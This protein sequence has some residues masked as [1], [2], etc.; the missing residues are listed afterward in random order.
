MGS[1]R[2]AQV[3]WGQQRDDWSEDREHDGNQLPDP[4]KGGMAQCPDA[5]EIVSFRAGDRQGSRAEPIPRPMT[6][7]PGSDV[8]RLW[9]L[10]PQSLHCF[11]K[12]VSDGPIT[13]DHVDG[14]DLPWRSV[15]TCAQTSRS[16]ISSSG[17]AVLSF[18]RV[19][20]MCFDDCVGAGMDAGRTPFPKTRQSITDSIPTPCL[21]T[22]HMCATL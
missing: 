4:V 2:H 16:W 10:C 9:T 5:P 13:A 17:R 14:D 22:T 15:L 20:A 3:G 7:L 12:A 11:T 19:N 21:Y 18:R 8:N 6:H 1:I